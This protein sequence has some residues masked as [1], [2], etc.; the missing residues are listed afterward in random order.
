MNLKQKFR[1]DIEARMAQLEK[2][3]TLESQQTEW[4][5]M[6]DNKVS[7]AMEL[8]DALEIAVG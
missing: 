5:E 4:R 1:K 8:A 3:E 7:L 2:V 6:L